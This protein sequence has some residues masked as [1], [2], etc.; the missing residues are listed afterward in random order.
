MLCVGSYLDGNLLGTE[1]GADTGTSQEKS[2]NS[3]AGMA[4]WRGE[5]GLKTG[6]GPIHS[7]A[8]EI[9]HL[10]QRGVTKLITN[11]QSNFIRLVTLLRR[12]AGVSFP[13]LPTPITL[14]PPGATV[15]ESPRAI[16]SALWPAHQPPHSTRE[17][18]R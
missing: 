18:T 9:V 12:Y 1:H 8:A 13:P 4:G 17:I 14:Y 3:L 15:E 2:L 11:Q 16:M 5:G 10:D 7:P 6:P